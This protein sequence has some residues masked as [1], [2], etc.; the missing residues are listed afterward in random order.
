[1]VNYER[2]MGCDH[3]QSLE[4]KLAELGVEPATSYPQVPYAT[5]WAARAGQMEFA[6][7]LMENYRKSKW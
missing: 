2:G 1:M 6:F 3:H 7:E 4:K 5:E